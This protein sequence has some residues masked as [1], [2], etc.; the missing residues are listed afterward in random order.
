MVKPFLTTKKTGFVNSN[1][2]SRETGLFREA[3]ELF[4]GDS[5]NI[6]QPM[7]PTTLP[8]FETLR[9][10]RPNGKASI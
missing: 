8:C 3:G 4:R 5:T 10:H 6:H 1:H 9:Q 2:S 7:K